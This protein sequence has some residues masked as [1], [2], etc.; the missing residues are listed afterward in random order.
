M[1]WDV[2]IPFPRSLSATLASRMG[3]LNTRYRAELL[4]K[5][6][7]PGER[8]N[9]PIVVDTA[10]RG[11]NPPLGRDRGSFDDNQTG[12]ANGTR[13]EMYQVPIV[14]IAILTRVLA[15]RCNGDSVFELDLFQ[16][17]WLE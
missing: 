10:A 9:V 12:P 16:S 13:P 4:D 7:D 3:Q 14:D 6:I 1:V 5:P 15:H 8:I 2:A 11:T 17:K